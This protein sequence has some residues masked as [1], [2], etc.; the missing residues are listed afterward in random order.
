MVVDHCEHFRWREIFEPR[1]T[2]VFV[3]TTFRVC[4]FGKNSPLN[5]GFQSSAFVLLKGVQV[6]QPLQEQQVRNLLDNFERVGD[7]AGPEGVPDGIDL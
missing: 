2:E 5:G 6:V 4:T 3:T 1:P 7:A